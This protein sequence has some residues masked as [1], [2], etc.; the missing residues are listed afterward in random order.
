[1][2]LDIEYMENAPISRRG[3]WNRE[4]IREDFDRLFKTARKKKMQAIK[5]SLNS[6]YKEYRNEDLKKIDKNKV[7]STKAVLEEVLQTNVYSRTIDGKVYIIIEVPPE[8]EA[9]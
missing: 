9:Q 2:A 4:Q 5:V 3:K 7:Y 1:M 6:L 8:G